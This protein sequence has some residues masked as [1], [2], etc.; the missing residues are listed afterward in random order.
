M[1]SETGEG[2]QYVDQETGEVPGRGLLDSETGEIELIEKQ[3]NLAMRRLFKV[4]PQYMKPKDIGEQDKAV[5]TKIGCADASPFSA[6]F[7]LFPSVFFFMPIMGCILA[8]LE[9]TLHA[10]AHRKNAILRSKGINFIRYQSPMHGLASEFCAACRY[11]SAKETIG[12]L[13]DK[14]NRRF[15]K[16]G[17]ECIKQIA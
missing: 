1:D 4:P 2:F 10:W 12:K 9:I 16:F 6:M 14:W 5:T 11:E 3:P 13:Q 17:I 7:F 15:I 8:V